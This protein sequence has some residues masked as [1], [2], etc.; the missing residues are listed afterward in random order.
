MKKRMIILAFVLLVFFAIG[1][2]YA[3]S[4]TEPSFSGRGTNTLR[5]SNPNPVPP[6]GPQ[7]RAGVGNLSGTVCVYYTDAAGEKHSSNYPFSVAAGETNILVVTI[8]GA[9][10]DGWSTISCQVVQSYN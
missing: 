3:Q 8:P 2:I 1:T 5:A 9:T 6:S 4:Y 10:I 7:R